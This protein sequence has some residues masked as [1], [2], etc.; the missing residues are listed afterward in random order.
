MPPDTIALNRTA[1]ALP[2]AWRVPLIRLAAAWAGLFVLT[3]QDWAA[4]AHQWWNVSTYNHVLFVP[5]IVG[6]LVWVRRGELA[7]IAPQAWWPGLVLLAGALFVWLLG[8]LGG[9]NIVGQLG[10]VAALQA[11]VLTLLGPR[12]VA[13]LL[14]PIVYALFL[15]PFGDELVPALQTV[16]ANMTIVL[17]EWSGISAEV[18]GVFIDTPVGL[19]EV[20]EAC[21]GVQ[22]LVA[23]IAL[24][25]LVAHSC[26]RSWRRRVVF[27]AAALALPILANGV[28]A[29]GT[30]FIAQSQGIEFA[31]GF[32]H[33]FYG[34]IFFALVVAILLGAFWRW[35]DRDP[36]DPQVDGHTLAHDPRLAGF[37]VGG[38]AALGA[39][40]ALVAVFAL[41]LAGASRV[42][43]ELPDD[44][45]P[46]EISGW[47]MVEASPAI[48][49][50]P[51]AAGADRRLLVRYRDRS[52]QDVDI[53]LALYAAQDFR[54]DATASGEGALPPASEW[55]WLSS[56]PAAADA[57]SDILLAR[58]K[59]KRLAQTSWRTGNLVTSSAPRMKLAAMRD[60]VLLRSRPTMMLIVSAEGSDTA[61]LV[62]RLDRFAAAMGERGEW[63]DRTAGVR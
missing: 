18:D 6:W 1:S 40:L 51:R 43:A 52:G 44:L 20:A 7:K 50:L 54:R 12:I 9:V 19:F 45:T 15:V 39:L 17:T 60:S 24:A 25:A 41:W 35:F 62:D 10:A 29:W 46:P 55:R 34:W 8:T 49:W 16:T 2:E 5:V 27:L 61:E 22:F 57:K 38:N 11:A 59:V 36:D 53:F 14:F 13:A 21:S 33:I 4:M 26:F 56:G 32:D 47:I 31:A 3:R 28:R 23:M 58:G 37:A 42:E 48:E 63:M 30:I